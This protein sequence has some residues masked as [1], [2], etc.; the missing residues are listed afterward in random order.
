MSNPPAALDALTTPAPVTL[1][2]V[3]LLEKIKSPLVLPDAFNPI[4]AIQGLYLLSLP[5]AEGVK[6]LPT[7]DSD[8]YAWADTLTPQDFGNRLAD[9]LHAL[10]NF[11][12]MIP[13][14]DNDAKKATPATAG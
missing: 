7:L 14:G 3:A 2:Q 11:Y 4:D 9:A 1:G 8:A 5:A 10:R 12:A 6:H 13:G